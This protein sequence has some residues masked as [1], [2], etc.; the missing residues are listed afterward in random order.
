MITRKHLE[1]AWFLESYT[2]TDVQSGEVVYPMGRN[3]EGLILY[4]SD[5]YMSAQLGAGR[6][7]RFKSDDLYSGTSDE[8]ATAGR[9][10][11][12]YSGPFY[13]EEK[14]GRLEH[15]MFVSFFPNWKGQRQV[16]VVAIEGNR[17]HLG[18]DHPMPFNG[19]LKNASLVWRRAV[20]QV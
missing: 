18:P 9:S 8:Y 2:E 1:G 6:R 4:T 11:I 16:R 7:A 19:R 20:P 3:P 12:A 15:E 14:S 5:G 17:L 10:Y 13:F